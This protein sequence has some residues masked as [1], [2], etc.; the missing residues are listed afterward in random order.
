M[1]SHD[2]MHVSNLVPSSPHLIKEKNDVYS[3]CAY[4]LLADLVHGMFS[5]LILRSSVSLRLPSH[6]VNALG[7]EGTVP[8]LLS[9]SVEQSCGLRPQQNQ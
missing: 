4:S 1:D 2:P 6:A 8:A 3:A 5:R 7:V 9:L